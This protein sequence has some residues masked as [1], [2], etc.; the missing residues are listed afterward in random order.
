VNRRNVFNV[1]LAAALTALLTQ[2]VGWLGLLVVAMLWGVLQKDLSS[3]PI[4]AGLGAALGWLLLLV[5]NDPRA[6]YGFARILS[7]ALGIPAAALVF[8]TLLL[9]FALTWSMTILSG[10]ARGWIR[11]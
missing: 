9:P 7:G 6:F 4:Q 1:L 2:A 5:Q 3:S 10:R 8:V 11:K